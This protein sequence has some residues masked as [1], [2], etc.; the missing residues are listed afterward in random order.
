MFINSKK[1]WKEHFREWIGTGTTSCL[2][3]FP[4]GWTRAMEKS[5]NW[6]DIL[7]CVVVESIYCIL[8]IYDIHVQ[9]RLM[10]LHNIKITR[11]WVNKMPQTLTDTHIILFIY[12]CST[13]YYFSS[14][15]MAACLKVEIEFICIFVCQF[16]YSIFCTYFP[17]QFPVPCFL[18]FLNRFRPISA[19][20]G[21][22]TFFCFLRHFSKNQQ[23][24]QGHKF[25][26][27]G[28]EH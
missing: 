23:I 25:L 14:F 19:I 15:F 8:Q 22:R 20:I 28:G 21:G 10:H 5:G 9:I 26:V 18:P 4:F 12:F 11:L 17:L 6:H 24:A 16:S 7:C 1:N 13:H 2:D 3:G 27:E